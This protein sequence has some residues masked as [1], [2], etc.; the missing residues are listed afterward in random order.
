MVAIG[1]RWRW[2][3]FGEGRERS[4]KM[5][6]DRNKKEKEESVLNEFLDFKSRIYSALGFFVKVSILIPDSYN[7]L[8]VDSI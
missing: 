6:R 3:L 7:H 1:A 5:G 8:K 2:W 4:K